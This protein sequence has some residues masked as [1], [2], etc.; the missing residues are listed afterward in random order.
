MINANYVVY[1][2]DSYGDYEKAGEYDN[3]YAVVD[4]YLTYNV[5]LEDMYRAVLDHDGNEQYPCSKIFNYN[6]VE[7]Y[8]DLYCKMVLGKLIETGKFCM[9]DNSFYIEVAE[10]CYKI[11]VRA[12]MAE[13]ISANKLKIYLPCEVNLV[14]TPFVEEPTYILGHDSVNDLVNFSFY[15]EVFFTE[16]QWK[17]YVDKGL[18][19]ADI[20]ATVFGQ[21]HDNFK[22]EFSEERL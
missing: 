3:W 6:D 17:A 20:F 5:F 19:N 12:D 8:F 14:K 18:S 15:G 21:F 9:P 11:V 16:S 2:R 22:V 13:A 10:D 4:D 1:E 7:Y